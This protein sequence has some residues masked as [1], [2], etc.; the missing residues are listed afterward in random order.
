MPTIA[1]EDDVYTR[2]DQRANYF[3]EEALEQGASQR[4]VLVYNHHP[5]QNLPLL[6]PKD[7]PSWLVRSPVV[8]VLTFSLR[9]MSSDLIERLLREH[10]FHILCLMTADSVLLRVPTTVLP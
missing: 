10:Q 5:R 7:T 2:K 6:A 9:V 3:V 4:P 1:R 8:R